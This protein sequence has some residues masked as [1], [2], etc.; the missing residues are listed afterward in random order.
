MYLLELRSIL[1]TLFSTVFLELIVLNPALSD[2]NFLNLDVIIL[3]IA[4]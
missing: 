1:G 3:K 4:S 2:I